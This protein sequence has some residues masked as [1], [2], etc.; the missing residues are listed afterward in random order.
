MPVEPIF[1]VFAFFFLLILTLASCTRTLSYL[2][3]VWL[4][5]QPTTSSST[6]EATVGPLPHEGGGGGTDEPWLQ[7][8]LQR[9]Q[10]GQHLGEITHYLSGV[11]RPK[12]SSS[13]AICLS[14]RTTSRN[15]S[16]D[17]SPGGVS[18]TGATRRACLPAAA[19]G[20]SASR[21]S[22]SPPLTRTAVSVLVTP[23]ARLSVRRRR[24]RVNRGSNLEFFS[25][26]Q[27]DWNLIMQ[28]SQPFWAY[29]KT[30]Y[31]FQEWKIWRNF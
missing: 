1:C 3:I 25:V 29:L 7:F 31:C 5:Q 11:Q 24:Q 14:S 15:S 17:A 16:R 18:L 23:A 26:I 27:F 8:A 10:T 9:S 28:L 4:F 6:E 21:T 2:L 20:S 13:G 19:W 22:S 30:L 12:Y